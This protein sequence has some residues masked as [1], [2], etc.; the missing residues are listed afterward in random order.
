MLETSALAIFDYDLGITPNEWRQWLGHVNIGIN[1]WHR[2]ELISRP[3]NSS[4]TAW[5][6][7]LMFS[8]HC[9]QKTAIEAQFLC[10]RRVVGELNS[11]SHPQISAR[12]HTRLTT[13]ELCFGMPF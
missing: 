7:L 2:L 8:S 3:C 12:R 4:Y 9:I 10:S 5:A 1:A 11:L 13:K 6:N